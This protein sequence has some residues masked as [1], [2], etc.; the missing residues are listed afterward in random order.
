MEAVARLRNNPTSPRKMR[1]LVD[2]IRGMEVEKAVN[3]L[4]FNAQHASQ[5]LEKLLL[6]A[7]ANWK[8][9]NEGEDM[10]NLIVKTIFVDCS[11]T[12]KRMMPAPQGRAHR[13]LKRSNHVTIIVDQKEIKT[14]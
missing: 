11:R 6:S 13:K 14:N 9:K 2:V 4:K 1:L 12:I 3:F 7:V 10:S 5:P 8:A